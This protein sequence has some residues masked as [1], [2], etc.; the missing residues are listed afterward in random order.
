MKLEP[1]LSLLINGRRFPAKVL[2]C[3]LAV[4][5]TRSQKKAANELGISPPVLNK[6]I[7]RAERITGAPLVCKTPF[8]SKLTET[9]LLIVGEYERL[10]RRMEEH[11]G[12]AIGCTPITQHVVIRAC[13]GLRI[14]I[15]DDDANLT[16][17]KRGEIDLVFFD[18]PLHVYEWEGAGE[19]YDIFFDTL[20]HI[21]KG[22]GKQYARFKYGAQ[23]VGFE[24]LTRSGV[25]YRIR[26]EVSDIHS[27]VG[28][29]FSFFI[30]RS[31]ATR[32]KLRLKPST[33]TPLFRHAITALK[34]REDKRL[35]EVIRTVQAVTSKHG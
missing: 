35:D 9:A 7:K 23:R 11:K 34:V 27:L 6:Y 26:K 16:L 15:G 29:G 19:S 30:N 31:L 22:D 5:H 10:S 18:D 28:S 4:H 25:D 2:D 20:L 33:P 3:L 13:H 17:L 21:R 14:H 12:I 8:G 32:E 1:R 24:Y